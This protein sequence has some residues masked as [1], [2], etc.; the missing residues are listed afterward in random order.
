[1]VCP[2]S[3]VLRWPTSLFFSNRLL[4][5]PCNI[6]MIMWWNLGGNASDLENRCASCTKQ[7]SCCRKRIP[8][9]GCH[10]REEI[11][12]YSWERWDGFDWTCSTLVW[13]PLIG[14]NRICLFGPNRGSSSHVAACSPWIITHL[15]HERVNLNRPIHGPLWMNTKLKW[16]WRSSSELG[17]WRSMQGWNWVP[18]YLTNAQKGMSWKRVQYLDPV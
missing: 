16:W 15:S 4:M 14:P 6:Y 17:S 11:S 1:M 13:H 5:A 7:P 2:H 12:F 10:M 18:E 9:P 3:R 8:C